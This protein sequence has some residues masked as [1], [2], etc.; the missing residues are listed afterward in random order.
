MRGVI[1]QL[2][3]TSSCRGAKHAVVLSEAKGQHYF[4]FY[5]IRGGDILLEFDIPKK[6]VKLIKMC[7]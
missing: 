5:N 6:L 7:F 1:L 4:Y 3:N 2:P